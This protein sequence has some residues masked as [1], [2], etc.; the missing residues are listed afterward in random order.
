[1][2][3]SFFQDLA[4]YFL[5]YIKQNVSTFPQNTSGSCHQG[6]NLLAKAMYCTGLKAVY[7]L[8]QSFQG[9]QTIKFD[10]NLKVI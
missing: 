6:W 10:L 5:Y 4:P 1:M 3:S 9:K 2:T 8:F 7:H